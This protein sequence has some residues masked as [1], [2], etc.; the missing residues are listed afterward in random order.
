M[1]SSWVLSCRRSRQADGK[2][3]A[4][5]EGTVHHHLTVMRL[6]DMLDNRQPQSSAANCTTAS[7]ID[8]I[9]TF[10][11]P[12]QVIFRDA[13]AA[14]LN[15]DLELIIILPPFDRDH[16]LCITVLDGIVHQVEMY[17]RQN[18]FL[19]LYDQDSFFVH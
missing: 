18:V 16:A 10:K 19:V 14:V 7:C 1:K 15:L 6:D 13:L 5:A 9:E 12:G 4:F 17:Q 3:N 8:A 11:N 2:N